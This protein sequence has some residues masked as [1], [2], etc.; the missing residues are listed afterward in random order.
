MAY[1][2]LFFTSIYSSYLANVVNFIKLS[3]GLVYFLSGDLLKI[4]FV[5]ECR[6][7]GTFFF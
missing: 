6:K 1:L 4:K 7:G 5:R 2:I 3:F